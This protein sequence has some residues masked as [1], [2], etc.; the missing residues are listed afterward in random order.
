MHLLGE[1]FSFSSSFFLQRIL[2]LETFLEFQLFQLKGASWLF[3]GV[4]LD[5]IKTKCHVQCKRLS[6]PQNLEL[7]WCYFWKSATL[8]QSWQTHFINIWQVKRHHSSS[9]RE[10]DCLPVGK[11]DQFPSLP[12]RRQGPDVTR[13]GGSQ[14]RPR[15]DAVDVPQ[16]RGL[17]IIGLS[18]TLPN[19]QLLADS[20][21][22]PKK[23]ALWWLMC[24]LFQCQ[25][26]ADKLQRSRRTW[27]MLVCKIRTSGFQCFV[28]L[29]SFSFLMY[30][31]GLED[32]L[33]AQLYVCH[34]RPVPL[35]MSVAPKPQASLQ[36]SEVALENL[37]S[38]LSYDKKPMETNGNQFWLI[39]K[40][41]ILSDPTT[42][43]FLFPWNLYELTSMGSTDYLPRSSCSLSTVVR[44]E[45]RSGCTVNSKRSGWFTSIGSGWNGGIHEFMKLWYKLSE[46]DSRI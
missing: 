17:Q 40:N 22:A 37:S 11:L 45:M 27:I 31:V 33:D 30:Y 6:Y 8:N 41:G 14:P 13:W 2:R 44:C 29:D 18:A 20:S 39:Y 15:V 26:Q 21:T 23:K 16:F 19:V 46:N 5:Q 10:V 4:D 24:P 32:W 9:K 1:E 34:E 43:Q 36:D 3:V 12:R 38:R 42:L 35:T 7:L 25:Y 28:C